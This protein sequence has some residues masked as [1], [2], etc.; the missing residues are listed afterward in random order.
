MDR[1]AW[2]QLNPWLE[3]RRELRHAHTV[4]MAHGGVPLVVIQRQLGQANLGV[5]SVYLQ[6]IHSSRSSAPSTD[7]HHRRSPPTP[8]SS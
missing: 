5:A 7:G 1:G 3:I 4:E 2:D 8:A 6:G